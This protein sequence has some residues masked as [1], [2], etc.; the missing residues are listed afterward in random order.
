MAKGAF[1]SEIADTHGVSRT[2]VCRIVHEFVRSINNNLDNI[3]FPTDRESIRMQKR[4]FY[5][6]CR[7]PNI[8]GAVDGTLIPIIAPVVDEDIYVCRKGYHAINCQGIVSSKMRF[9]NVVARWPGSTH[10]AAIFENCNLKDY[11]EREENMLLLG[12]SGYALSRYLLTPIRYPTT[13]EEERYNR[14]H[15]HGREVVERT[16]GILKS[17]F[18][19]LH[20]S[21]GV[22]PFA[23]DK[24]A[25]VF[26]ACCRLHNM[27]MEQNE[28]LPDVSFTEND[29]VTDVQQHDGDQRGLAIRQFFVRLN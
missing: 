6:K 5:E 17:R 16:F 7:F 1:Y 27:C 29:T 8:V 18:R 20:R 21:G 2:S 26:V 15:K 3:H 19:C 24:C 13:Q 25:A 28:P 10:D 23:P 14:R 12:D 4:A 11:L 22:L 9:T